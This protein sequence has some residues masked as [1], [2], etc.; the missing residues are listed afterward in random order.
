MFKQI[1][2]EITSEKDTEQVRSVIPSDPQ[3]RRFRVIGFAKIT[4]SKGFQ[5][6]AQHIPNTPSTN[7]KIH[8]TSFPERVEQ[9]SEK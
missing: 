1:C 3:F 5:Q 4:K 8:S 7:T 6:V 2:P 9:I